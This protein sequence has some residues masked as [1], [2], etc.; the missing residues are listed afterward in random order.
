MF[1]SLDDHMHDIDHEV[2]MRA[3]VIRWVAY[4]VVA[5]VVFG[6]LYF[7]IRLIE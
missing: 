2:S 5:L 1:E 6:G 4:V 3:R 7:G